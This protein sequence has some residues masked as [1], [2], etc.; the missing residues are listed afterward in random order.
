MHKINKLIAIHMTIIIVFIS[1]TTSVS[2]I[3]TKTNNNEVFKAEYTTNIEIK[4]ESLKESIIPIKRDIVK[5]SS[6]EYKATYDEIEETIDIP[7]EIETNIE[8]VPFGISNEEIELIALVT[9]AEAE[10]ECEEGKRLVIDTILNR[11][12]SEHFPNTINEVIYQPH[13]FSSMWN[14]RVDRC[15]VN[16]DICQLVKEELQ[17]RYNS[18][19]VFFCA[20]GYSAYRV[21]MF[22]VENHYFS[23]YTR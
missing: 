11:V 18:E 19:V 9:M 14:G 8:E 20:Y 12:D 2:P 7:A 3:L 5:E 17:S 21:P 15:Y 16:E 13:Q 4:K 10:G 1:F 23:S 6:I 22:Q